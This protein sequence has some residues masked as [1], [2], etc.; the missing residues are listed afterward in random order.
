MLRRILSSLIG[1]ALASMSAMADS[2]CPQTDLAETAQDCP[3]AGLSRDL[4]Q[5]A[6]GGASTLKLEALLKS[7]QPDLASQLGQMKDWQGLWGASINFDELAKGVIVDPPIL[8]ALYG[9]SGVTP[10][11]LGADMPDNIQHAGLEH[12]YGYLFSVLK[13]AFGYKR[14]R[15]VSG[16]IDQGFSLP[17][18]A[19]SPAPKH[20]TL[21]RNVTYFTGRIAFRHDPRTAAMLEKR[22][23]QV[24]PA[25]LSF[26]YS[27][28][29]P[30][31]VEEQ[32][33]LGG[34]RVVTLRTDLI[35]F[36]APS[37]GPDQQLLVYSY[38]DSKEA[39]PRLVTAFPVAQSFGDGLVKPETLGAG[40]PIIT[41]YNAYIAGFTG[42]S[43][44]KGSRT[45]TEHP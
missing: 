7:R 16:E 2:Q 44:L 19:I 32:V 38:L 27:D 21:F 1:V 11:Q 23:G 26:K 9:L 37:G 3:W 35:P 10:P 17:D 42:R 4:S 13:T 39:R 45:V 22:R 25:L 12:T 5:A 31:R 30:T 34:G 15:W 40:Q 33:D 29:K 41:R 6:A 43:D 14:S 28:L 24:E 18:G 36:T 20:G 8:A